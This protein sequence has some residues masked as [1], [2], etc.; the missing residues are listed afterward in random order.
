MAPPRSPEPSPAP[1]PPPAPGRPARRDAGLAALLAAA[2]TALYA[3]GSDLL[4]G[5]DATGRVYTAA[6]L[7]ATGQPAIDPVRLPFLF[8]WRDRRPGGG[9]LQLRDLAAPVD[10]APAAARVAAGELVPV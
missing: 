2:L 3:G 5:N 4:P 1:A 9:T 8:S 7:L 10:G 6:T